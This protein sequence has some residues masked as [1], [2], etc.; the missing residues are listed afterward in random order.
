MI[1]LL[2]ETLSDLRDTARAKVTETGVAAT[3]V[4]GAWPDALQNS[5]EEDKKVSQMTRVK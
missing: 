2:T 4:G 5:N 3:A 1:R